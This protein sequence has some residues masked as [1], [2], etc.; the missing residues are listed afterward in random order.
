[1]SSLQIAVPRAAQVLVSR[2]NGPSRRRGHST[3][4]A[5]N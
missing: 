5:Q 1:V 4:T 2:V 3:R